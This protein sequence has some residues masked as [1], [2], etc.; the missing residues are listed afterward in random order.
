[1]L[2]KYKYLYRETFSILLSFTLLSK[3]S[4]VSCH[5]PVEKICGLD[6][7]FLT[8]NRHYIARCEPMA[9]TDLDVRRCANTTEQPGNTNTTV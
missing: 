1:M 3:F 7:R 8:E 9:K 6:L 5:C 4:P 2:V